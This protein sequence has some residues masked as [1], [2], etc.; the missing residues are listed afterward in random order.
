[1]HHNEIYVYDT[2][3]KKVAYSITL[4]G[5]SLVRDF[6]PIETGYIYTYSKLVKGISYEPTDLNK[7]TRLIKLD[8]AVYTIIEVS[9]KEPAISI[10]KYIDGKQD[11]FHSSNNFVVSTNLY[12]SDKGLYS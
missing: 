3:T 1:M 10:Y 8:S 5:D 6:V 9:E 4:N 2:I 7:I 11:V 12:P